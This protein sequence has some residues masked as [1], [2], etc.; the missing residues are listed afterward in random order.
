MWNSFKTLLIITRAKIA[1]CSSVAADFWEVVVVG[2]FVC[3]VFGSSN[4]TSGRR[5]E[6]EL[7]V[8]G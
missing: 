7:R 5:H 2:P 3:L 4:M 1:F 6:S 8:S